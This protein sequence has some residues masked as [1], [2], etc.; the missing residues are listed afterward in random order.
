MNYFIFVIALFVAVYGGL[1]FYV[2]RKLRVVFSGHRRSVIVTIV[3]LGCLIFVVEIFTHGNV[4]AFFLAPLTWLTFIWMGC[5]FLFFVISAPLDIVQMIF[6]RLRNI[7]IT[8][9]LASPRRTW[10]VMAAVVMVGAYGYAAARQINIEHV[11]LKSP[12]IIKPIRIV[13]IADLHL[14][15]MSEER[16]IQRIVDEINA[17]EP[18]IIVSTGDLVDMQM[19]DL[20]GLLNQMQRL[21]ARQGKF[22]VYGNHEVLAGIDTARDFTEH[23]GFVLL[24]GS[25]I[26]INSALNIAGVDDPAVK[27][28]LQQSGPDEAALLKQFDNGLFTLQLKHQPVVESASIGRF[29]L[30]LSGHIHGG[31]IF[32]FGLLTWAFYRIPVGL[33]LA[34]DA[35]WIYVSRGTGTW[36]P[37][38]RVLAP[39]E[40]TLIDLKPERVNE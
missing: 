17:L 10:L 6:G 8:G 28:R 7:T 4:S 24:S 36:G 16:H 20:R 9:I 2:Y 31:Q 13:Q 19:D 29:D 37:P 34:G 23:A 21:Y 1:H 26:T 3:I 32:P 14:G 30:Q 33:S 27:R 18:D 12:K 5:V 15:L 40:I 39:P 11:V 35:G 38:M 22:A 25:G